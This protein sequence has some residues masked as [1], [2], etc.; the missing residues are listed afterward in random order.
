MDKTINFKLLYRASKDGNSEKTFHNKCDNISGTLTIIKT[1]KG[2]RFGGYTEKTWN[3]NNNSGKIDSKGIAFCFSLYLFKIYNHINNNSIYCYSNYGPPFRN[4]IH[5]NFPFTTKE[6]YTY[7]TSGGDSF[8]K[9]EKDY[10]INNY[11]QYFAIQEL[12]VLCYT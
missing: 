2:I 7:T 12:E 3:I 6:N 10:E 9:F 5:T 1:T 11:Q 8:D 4:L